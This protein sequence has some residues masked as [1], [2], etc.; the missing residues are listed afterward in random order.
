M[1]SLET[2]RRGVTE[3]F[4]RGVVT[5]LPIVLTVVFLGLLFQIVTRY[6][7]GPIN[8]AIYWS[9][10]RNAIGWK[11]L[12]FLDVDPLAPTYL[13]PQLLPLRLQSL[14]GASPEGFDD[15]RFEE[16]LAVYRRDHLGFLRDPDDLALRADRLREAV[17]KR[18]HPLVGV[19]LSLLLV[20]WLG[21]LASGWIGRRF[22]GHLDR[23]VML[24]PIV[25]SVY[26]HSK[27]L[28][29]FFFQRRKRL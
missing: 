9:L 26:P 12:D 5:L 20:L 18:V 11:V 23:M 15:P 1:K 13:A 25:N 21:W 17:R 10:E 4:L 24:V 14:A 8:S 27:Q 16:A 7:T 28:V 19:V 29:E 22:V 6:V 3:H 2:S